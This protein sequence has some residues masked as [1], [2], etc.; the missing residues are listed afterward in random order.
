MNR[1]TD[2]TWMNFDPWEC[3]GQDNY[4]QRGCHE[5]GGCTNGCIVPKLYVRLAKYE[6]IGFTP[7]EIVAKISSIALTYDELKDFC[8]TKKAQFDVRPLYIAVDRIKSPH[9]VV[10]GWRGVKDVRFAFDNY[11][12]EYDKTWWAYWNEPMRR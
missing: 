4:C 8:L 1:L 2:E 3:C 12:N 11:G 5:N 10:Y 7:E 9:I 6:D